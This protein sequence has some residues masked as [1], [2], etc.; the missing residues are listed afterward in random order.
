MNFRTPPPVERQLGRLME[1]LGV[2]NRAEVIRRA[3]A[4][5][6]AAMEAL[7]KG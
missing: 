2:T 6:L 4:F 1:L 7:R 5:Y 3:L